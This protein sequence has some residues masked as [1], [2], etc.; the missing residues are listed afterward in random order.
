MLPEY[1]EISEAAPSAMEFGKTSKIATRMLTSAS[2][3][4]HKLE[5]QNTSVF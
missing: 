3:S 5:C 1:D 2:P 4:Q